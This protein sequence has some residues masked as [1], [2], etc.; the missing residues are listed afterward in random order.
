MRKAQRKRNQEKRSEV[1]GFW[2]NLT[3]L[4]PSLAVSHWVND[5]I[6]VPLLHHNVR[7]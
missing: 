1:C 4:V 6:S 2:T 7:G 5:W 3:D